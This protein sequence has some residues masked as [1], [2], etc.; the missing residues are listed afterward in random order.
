[1]RMKGIFSR[2]AGLFRPLPAGVVALREGDSELVI[3]KDG[4][5]LFHTPD[6]ALSHAEFVSRTTGTLPE[7]AWVGTIRKHGGEVVAISSRTFFGYQ[8]PAP[9]PVADAIHAA[10]R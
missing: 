10:F 8:L 1:M 9:P 2:L 4:E 5:V 7:G 3:V 6:V